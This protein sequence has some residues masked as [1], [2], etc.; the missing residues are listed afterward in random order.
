MKPIRSKQHLAFI[1]QLNCVVCG[2]DRFVEAAHVGRRGMGQ[3]C[4]DLETIPLCRIHHQE[5]HRIGLKAFAR[6]YELDIPA[7]LHLLTRKPVI[8][9]W[10]RR[11]IAYWGDTVSALHPVEL[12]LP[13]SMAT[14]KTLIHEHVSQEI[15]ARQSR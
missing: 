8:R 4:S 14:L 5:Q 11:Y 9:V 6:I 7:L 12:G 13:K 10:E 1:R 3:K 15:L 2:R